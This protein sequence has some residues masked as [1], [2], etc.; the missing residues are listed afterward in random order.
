MQH[1]TKRINHAAYGSIMQHTRCGAQENK[2]RYTGT[3]HDQAC[4]HAA[5][6]AAYNEPGT[7]SLLM[8]YT[9]CL[10]MTR[11]HAPYK[12]HR[13]TCMKQGMQGAK[14]HHAPTHEV[15]STQ[16][17]HAP[18]HKA[19]ICMEQVAWYIVWNRLHFS[20]AQ[21]P[22]HLYGA[23][24]MVYRAR[25]LNSSRDSRGYIIVYGAGYII[26]YGAGFT[27]H[28]C[29]W[30]RLY[31]VCF[32]GKLHVHAAYCMFSSLRLQQPTLAT[33]TSNM[34]EEESELGSGDSEG[35]ALKHS[36]TEAGEWR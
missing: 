14:M 25:A 34:S 20:R 6:H 24:S 19:Y 2:A 3:M 11:M 27:R 15:C 30:C 23:G 16:L 9:C 31:C 28:Y 5:G 8:T 26:V 35:A 17:H 29:V 7:C 22:P 33:C 36:S 18:T 13:I 12:M 32:M 4:N 10:H 1:S 21:V